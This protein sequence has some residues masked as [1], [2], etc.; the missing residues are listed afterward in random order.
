[1]E[2]APAD[3]V[4]LQHDRH[5]LVLVQ[6]GLPPPAAFGVDGEGALE[7]VGQAEVVDHK[8]SGL[9]LEHAVDAGDGLHEPVAAHRLDGRPAAR[10][11]DPDADLARIRHGPGPKRWLLPTPAP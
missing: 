8:A 5:R 9:V 1:M 10:L 2:E 3:V 7:L 11:V 4:I 6:R